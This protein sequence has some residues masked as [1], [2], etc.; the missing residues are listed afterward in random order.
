MI[1]GNG[2]QGQIVAHSKEGVDMGCGNGLV[3]LITVKP[4]GKGEM[5]ASDWYNGVRK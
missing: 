1:D 5:K 4:E 3:R 2:V